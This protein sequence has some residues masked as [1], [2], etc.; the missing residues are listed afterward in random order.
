[1]PCPN[2]VGG[3]CAYVRPEAWAT[4]GSKAKKIIVDGSAPTDFIKE[5]CEGNYVNC[6]LYKLFRACSTFMEVVNEVNEVG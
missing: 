1:M 2:L 6:L 5:V 3:R 4:I